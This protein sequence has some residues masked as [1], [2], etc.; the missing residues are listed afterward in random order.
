MY[1]YLDPIN[2]SIIIYIEDWY[3]S[4]SRMDLKFIYTIK[5]ILYQNNRSN[6]TVTYQCIKILIQV[7]QV[8]SR[9]ISSFRASTI[10][11]IHGCKD[12]FAMRRLLDLQDCCQL[13][14]PDSFDP[15]HVSV[16]MLSKRLRIIF[17]V[18]AFQPLLYRLAVTAATLFHS[19]IQQS[20][21]VHDHRPFLIAA[22]PHVAQIRLV[23]HPVLQP[24]D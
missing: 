3:I 13:D 23:Q 11:A 17:Q 1:I 14:L 19:F 22:D 24:R 6:L 20:G 18:D 7:F 21:R 2:F 8:R 4:L 16:Q 9:A 15:I 12:A 5:L 10:R